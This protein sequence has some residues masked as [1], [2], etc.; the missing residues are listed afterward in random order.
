MKLNFRKSL[1]AGTAMIAV[2]AVAVSTSAHAAD[3]TLTGDVVWGTAATGMV[4][5]PTAGDNVIMTT[6]ALKFDASEAGVLTAGDVTATTGNLT[7][8]TT[9]DGDVAFTI[10]SFTG[11]STS[12]ILVDNLLASTTKDIALTFTN[13]VSTGG[14][15]IVRNT[16][17]AALT[18]VA[19]SVGGTTTIGGTTAI[20][21]GAHDS[22]STATLTTTGNATFTGLVTL[23]GGAGGAS[24]DAILNVN[25]ATNAFTAGLVLDDNAAN[26]D[27]VVNFAGA[28]AQSVTGVINAASTTD[29]GTVNVVAG[30]NAVT[31]ASQIGATATNLLAV[32]VGSA[33][34][35]GNAVF[36]GDVHA[37]TTT[38]HT[39]VADDAVADF[40]GNIVGALAITAGNAADELATVTASGNI[41]G[42]IA[43]SD[44]AGTAT[45]TLD[46]TALQ[47][48]TGDITVVAD[49]DAVINA[50]NDVTVIGDLGTAAA[51]LGALN[52]ATG[53]TF[54]LQV[55][56][57]TA[58]S[59]DT[60][61]LTGT[62]TLVLDTTTAVPTLTGNVAAAADGN[63][64][65][66]FTGA[67]NAV[68]NGNV[69]ASGT[70]VGAI[71][72]TA[73]TTAKGVTLSGDT[74]ANGIAIDATNATDENTVTLGNGADTV[75]ITGNIT[76]AEDG[77]HTIVFNA[78]TAASVTGSIGA[79]GSAMKLVTL[80]EGLTLGGN[81]YSTAATLAA[82]KTLV[83]NGTTAQTV[84]GTLDGAG[85]GQGILEVGSGTT[86]TD[87]T[88]AGVV[89]ATTLAS[90]NVKALATARFNANTEVAGALT[91][92][93]TIHV[94]TGA[95]LHSASYV[96]STGTIVL[97][98]TD[99]NVTL[100][101]AD[102]GTLDLGGA[103]S[104]DTDDVTIN[105]T[106]I[107]GTG[108]ADVLTNAGDAFDEAKLMVDNSALY[109]FTAA[110]DGT[111][112]VAQTAATSYTTTTANANTA[113]ALLAVPS[114]VTG[115][116]DTIK[117]SFAA[118][119]AGSAVNEVLE[120]AASTVDGGA[121]VAAMNVSNQT[122]G[123]ADMRMAALRTGDAVTSGMAAGNASSGVQYWGQ[124]FGTIADQDDRDGINGYD[125]DTLGFAVGLESEAMFD[126]MAVGLAFTYGNTEVDSENATTTNTEVD[127]YQ[128]TL[129]GDY[130]LD[131]STYVSGQMAYSFNDNDTT[132]HNV[133]GI[134]GVTA[135][136]G[137]DSDQISAR[138]EVGRAYP[139]DGTLTLTPSVN[140][141][142][143][144][145]SADTY[146]ETG[147][148]TANLTVDSDS[149]NA[150]E[151]G[152]GV[153]AAWTLEQADG[154][155]L[156]PVL[157]LGVRHDLIGD[158]FEATNTFAGG[159]TAFKTKGFD[160]ADTTLDAGVG[161]TYFSTENWDLTANYDVEYKS[162]Y[163]S[164]SGLLKAAYNF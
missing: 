127:S 95:L 101:A 5:T 7:I 154:S 106:G 57:A 121:V 64:V 34:V 159:G 134:S 44:D 32:N 113:T 116:L 47:T 153:A 158:E 117:D 43:L 102:F 161:V 36:S 26:G 81:L 141:A 133:G 105:V 120:A 69:G 126:N 40:N 145:Y 20:T 110:T 53:K 137:Y 112:T 90:A 50:N 91:N 93:G 60:T 63:G 88:F 76:S 104:L 87:V 114:T 28:A 103:A 18:T 138:V 11:S 1:L 48:L 25:G 35:G 39:Q 123:I 59:I 67:N 125:A 56:T 150:F 86:A 149:M 54:T 136:G 71:Q 19:M 129:Y 142:Y 124:A 8:D 45:L 9:G 42:A 152:L 12:D 52:V 109:T 128:F 61:T 156:K 55:A 15:L 31:F 94:G 6:H 140:M 132:R 164:H 2:G 157:S 21:G 22:A 27:A 46:G 17:A 85:A 98:L 3:L 37:A 115:H 139:M 66:K 83:F 162:D 49:S 111:I 29:E 4:A 82:G 74:Y 148:G 92:A 151:L 100:A 13:N 65:L 147:A 77:E 79:S 130:D 107:V 163:V 96:D 131:K 146:T 10:G 118:A 58:S 122:A 70:D 30:T 23:T 38:V 33:T 72:V 80:T 62:G 68:M 119:G 75:A 108:T 160:T 144:H 41:T 24:A 73:L 97:G 51:S 135:T 84:S 89:G 16:E 155:V 143:M 99:A 78:S 14:G